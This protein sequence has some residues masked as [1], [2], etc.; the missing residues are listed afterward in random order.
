MD[1]QERFTLRLS[2]NEKE[3]WNY[4]AFSIGYESVSEFIRDSINA[5][6]SSKKRPS[7][8]IIIE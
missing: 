2:K 7:K 8:L 1:K 6:I 4:Y 5:L 3:A